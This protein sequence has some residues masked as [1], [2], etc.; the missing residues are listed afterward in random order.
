MNPLKMEN[1][2]AEMYGIK[3]VSSLPRAQKGKIILLK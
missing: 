2:I 1:A 3:G